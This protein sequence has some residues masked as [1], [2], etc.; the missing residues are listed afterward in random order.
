MKKTFSRIFLAVVTLTVILSL[1][2]GAAEIFRFSHEVD[3]TGNG[4]PNGGYWAK[5]PATTVEASANKGVILN[6]A[7]DERVIWAFTNEQVAKTPYFCF[8]LPKDSGIYKVTLSKHWDVERE[9][10]L[11]FNE[12]KNVF[13][14]NQLL[15]DHTTIGYTYF[16]FYFA[17][18]APATVNDIYLSSVDPSEENPGT[19]DALAVAMIAAASCAVVIFKKKH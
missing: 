14:V 1:T 12:G 18:G 15:K 9:V 17:G 6:A 11:T 2:A 16:T 10:E 13:D 5:A 19:G 4:G 7:N 8:D 3:P